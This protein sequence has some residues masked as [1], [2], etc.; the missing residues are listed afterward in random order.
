MASTSTD[1]PQFPDLVPFPRLQMLVEQHEEENQQH[2]LVH[3]NTTKD[4]EDIA[5]V[6]KDENYC[7]VMFLLDL[8]CLCCLQY[9]IHLLNFS[10][11]FLFDSDK[12][13]TEEAFPDI[14]ILSFGAR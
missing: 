7:G 10:F 13:A 4:E 12:F 2:L 6:C 9:N 11:L 5:A 1:P 3:S 8:C 14:P